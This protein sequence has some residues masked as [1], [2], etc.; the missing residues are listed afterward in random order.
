[1][2]FSTT[3]DTVTSNVSKS[4]LRRL[5]MNSTP[6]KWSA[7]T[8]CLRDDAILV[9]ALQRS[10]T[11][12]NVSNGRFE[13]ALEYFRIAFTKLNFLQFHDKPAILAFLSPA[14]IHY[15]DFEPARVSHEITTIHQESSLPESATLIY[16]FLAHKYCFH[17][18]FVQIINGVPSAWRYDFWRNYFSE[19]S[20]ALGAVWSYANGKTIRVAWSNSLRGMIKVVRV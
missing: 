11:D 3:H 17:Y 7:I 16:S 14:C 13:L 19:N 1:M 4:W 20:Q 10:C 9:S 18:W 12:A 5:T 15:N 6:G 8:Q 2:L